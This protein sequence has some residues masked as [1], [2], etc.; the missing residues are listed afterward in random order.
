[1]TDKSQAPTSRE[2]RLWSIDAHATARRVT[3]N[4]DLAGDL[5]QE[6]LVRLMRCYAG[7]RDLHNWLFVVL[8]RLAAKSALRV[9]E[10][11][12]VYEPVGPAAANVEQSLDLERA[13]RTLPA[14]QARL[15]ALTLEG[16]SHAEIAQRIGCATHQVGPRV[17]RA[18]RALG[19]KLRSRM[20]A[21][22]L[23]KPVARELDRGVE[24]EPPRPDE[25][26]LGV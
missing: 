22:A 6:A 19:R 2:W 11:P 15:L 7:V 26:G 3:R 25:N 21:A 17:A 13:L 9:A 18:Q 23:S 1:M 24:L 12:L 8:R 4:S 14:R 16:Y 5:A 20:P 10:R